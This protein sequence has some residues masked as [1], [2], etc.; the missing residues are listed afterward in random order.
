MVLFGWK[1]CAPTTRI[2]VQSTPERRPLLNTPLDGAV[3]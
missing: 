1:T 3:C 2:E